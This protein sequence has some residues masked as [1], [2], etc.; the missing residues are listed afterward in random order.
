MPLRHSSKKS[1]LSLSARLVLPSFFIGAGELRM[2]SAEDAEESSDM[3]FVVGE[4]M[5]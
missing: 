5:Q 4:R 1:I 2:E 3:V